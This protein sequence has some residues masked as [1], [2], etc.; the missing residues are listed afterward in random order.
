MNVDLGFTPRPWQ[1]KVHAE[2]KRFNVLVCHRRAGKT[3]FAVLELLLGALAKANGRFAYVAPFYAQAKAV[4]WDILKQYALKIPGVTVRESDLQ[5]ELPNG[6]RVRLYGADNEQALRGIGLDGLVVDEVAD[7]VPS[8]WGEIL[9]PALADKRGWAIFIGTAH[10][11]NLFSELYYAALRDPDWYTL[12][13]RVED[14]GALH[15]DEVESA[16]RGM[17]EAQ[18]EAEF[19]CVFSAGGDNILITLER[20][21]AASERVI[22]QSAYHHAGKALACDPARFGDDATVIILRQGLAAHGLRYLRGA[23]TMETADAIASLAINEM[24]DG[25][26]VD[27]GGLGAG[28]VDRLRQLGHSVVGVNFGSRSSDPKYLNKRS[29]MWGE[30]AD[31]LKA[32]TIP[33]DERLKLDLASP[34]YKYDAQ[35][36]IVLESKDAMKSRGLKSPDFGDALAL[37]FASPLMSRSLN[38]DAR[39][40]ASNHCLTEYDPFAGGD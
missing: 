35:S 21:Q 14:S 25:I 17:S 20:V 22:P 36:R 34:T 10:G 32:G 39:A 15:P 18:F 11:I 16:R 33:D 12:L 40:A 29:Q 24:P 19:R 1:R 5:V 6:A 27:E 7:I 37:T 26:F 3:V 8:V 31:W 28:V 9:R 38:A 13:L 2:R 4:A 23:D 30:M